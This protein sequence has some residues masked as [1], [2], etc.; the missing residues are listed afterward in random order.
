MIY[1]TITQMQNRI[2]EGRHLRCQ[3][4][5]VKREEMNGWLQDICQFV[6]VTE[7]CARQNHKASK[8]ELIPLDILK[9]KLQ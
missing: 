4:V 2:D 8:S 3:Y 6:E 5:P 1:D 9:G 7:V